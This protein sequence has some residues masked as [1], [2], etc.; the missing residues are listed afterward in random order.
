MLQLVKL[1]KTSESELTL[2]WN[3]DTQTKISFKHLR[4]ECPC[5][6]CKGETVLFASTEPN[7]KPPETPGLYE[8]KNIEV[9]GNY[10]IQPTWGDGHASGLYSWEY[11]R[12][13]SEAAE[14]S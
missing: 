6:E 12:K 7:K 13:I 4:D 3:D 1:K 10:A 5:A 14:N 9:I 11:L 2:F 8:L